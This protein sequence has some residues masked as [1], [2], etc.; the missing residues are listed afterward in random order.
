[1]KGEENMTK[2]YTTIAGDMWDTVA[3]KTMG[4][5]SHTDKIIKA[6]SKF[7]HLVIFPAGIVLTIPEAETEYP[8]ELPPWKRGLL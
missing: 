3:Y 4:D 2:K 7:R 5:E 1:M 6:N 8:A